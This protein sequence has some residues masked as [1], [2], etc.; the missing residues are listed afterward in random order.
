MDLNGA[1]VA[2]IDV[3]APP[4][5]EVLQA[6]TVEVTHGDLMAAALVVRGVEELLRRGAE[7]DGVA[8]EQKE[9]GGAEG[10]NAGDPDVAEA[11]PV[12]ITEGRDAVSSELVRVGAEAVGAT[13]EVEDVPG[14]RGG[15]EGGE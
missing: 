10:A 5:D 9:P 14:V 13:G 6:V 7:P 12:E 4:D 11:V 8:P 1:F 15:G 3:L 2:D